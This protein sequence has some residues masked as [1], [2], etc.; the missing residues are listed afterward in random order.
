[1]KMLGKASVRQKL[2]V[3]VMATVAVALVVA[4]LGVTVSQ[5][6]QQKGLAQ[7]QLQTLAAITALNCRP[8]LAAMKREEAKAALE[9]LSVDPLVL[10]AIAYDKTRQAIAEYR[11]P[12]SLAM[13]DVSGFASMLA[14]FGLIDLQVRAAQPVYFGGNAIGSVEITRSLD[15]LRAGFVQ[16]MAVMALA[17]MAGL[18]AALVMAHRWLAYITAPL[19]SLVD[20]MRRVSK[21]GDCS[22]RLAKAS[23]DELG[24]L[25]EGFN[26]MLEQI[27]SKDRQMARHGELL[28]RKMERRAGELLKEKEQAEAASRAKSQFLATMSHEIRTPLSGVLGMAELLSDTALD[29]GQRKFM[30]NLRLSGEALLEIVE[31]SLDFSKIEAGRLEL[32][33]LDFDLPGLLED[34]AGLWGEHAKARGI[35][36]ELRL[37]ESVPP[38]VHGDPNRLRQILVNLLSN[39]VKFTERGQVLL[40]VEAGQPQ[41]PDKRQRLDFSVSDTGIGISEEAQPRLFQSFSQADGSTP[42]LYGGTGL[43][44]AISK[45]LVELMGGQIGVESRL[46]E[47]STFWFSVTLPIAALAGTP[48][49][50]SE[51]KPLQASLAKARAAGSG[52][53]GQPAN[54]WERQGE[55]EPGE[56]ARAYPR[57]QTPSLGKPAGKGKVLVA[58]DNPINQ[59]VAVGMLERLGCEVKVAGDGE[60]A[61]SVLAGEDFDLILM[62]C[63]MP[64]MD[65]YE[66][67]A[68]IRARQAQGSKPIP[69]VALTA[70]NVAGDREKCLQA[71]MDDYLAKPFTLHQLQAIVH[72]WLPESRER[73]CAAAGL[74]RVAEQAALYRKGFPKET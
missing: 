3:L 21:E 23:D 73:P 5:L 44:L 46:G 38:A 11:S 58:E 25:T 67:T 59:K 22:I 20:A 28:E 32:E 63:M 13:G 12:H 29:T 65:G 36:F 27:E 30:E 16:Q 24:E 45:Q 52:L 14:G 31:D 54:P 72:R 9:S 15:D 8:T 68:A 71:G 51:L 7:S 50:V 4:S 17:M 62:D 55:P 40:K 70:N 69:I 57:P 41:G 53:S 56:A 60:E 61:L 26:A 47:G 35:G 1:M 43:G 6:S 2:L 48:A 42:R 10:S 49:P 33:S 64:R 19:S 18:L 39:A 74:D 66:A 34:I 37:G